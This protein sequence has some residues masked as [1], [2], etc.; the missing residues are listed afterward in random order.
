MC[1]RVIECVSNFDAVDGSKVTPES[2]FEELGIHSL[3]AAEVIIALEDEFAIEI[4][5]AEADKMKSIK[6]VVDMISAHPA[7]K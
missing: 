4:P 2:T 1:D 5:D 3:E 7:A 6:D